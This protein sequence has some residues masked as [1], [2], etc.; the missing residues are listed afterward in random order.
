MFALP[1]ALLVGTASP[2]FTFRTD[3]FWL[4]LHQFLYVLGRAE[5]K[6][7]DA[8]RE[9][10]VHAPE[11]AERGL[12][13]ASEAERVLW[14]SA[15]AWYANGLSRQDAVFDS[16]LPELARALAT[17]GDSPEA[18][19]LSPADTEVRGV[20]QRVA[21]IYR[22]LWWPE[23]RDA[24]RQY[25]R[26]MDSLVTR[27]GDSVLAFVTRAYQLE[28]PAAGYPVHIAGYANWAGAFSTTGN[29]LIVSSLDSLSRR[30]YGLES[31][32]HEAM[33]QWDSSIDAILDE[34]AGRLGRRVPA[35][36]SHAMIFFTAGE[37]VRRVAPEHV[38][39]ADAF[40]VWQRRWQPMR[41]A[42]LEIWK[43]YL[44]GAGTR[45]DAIV[46][47]LERLTEP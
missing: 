9:A 18:P 27:Y 10:V 40:G 23:Q 1:L 4:N 15:V 31:I 7:F 44:D 22:K 42:L 24:N 33:H 20:L 21:P 41:D 12:Q 30:L 37:A 5:A 38:P 11:D 8:N 47:L 19:R 16:P 43:P 26:G 36:L 28:W 13:Q 3:E 17:A 39:Y 29:L 25:R 2:I 45:D 46:K 14:R 6:A 34:E 35:S 32:F